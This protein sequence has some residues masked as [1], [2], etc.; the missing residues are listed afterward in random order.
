M[1]FVEYASRF[2]R[3]CR[4]GMMCSSGRGRLFVY[5]LGESVCETVSDGNETKGA[6][7]LWWRPVLGTRPESR[8]DVLIFRPGLG[9]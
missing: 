7:G 9:A 2:L 1:V 8:K 5:R 3:E 6:K 4:R